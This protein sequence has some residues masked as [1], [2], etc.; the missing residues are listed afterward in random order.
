MCGYVPKSTT[1]LAEA[2]NHQPLFGWESKEKL[3]PQK[4]STSTKAKVLGDTKLKQ[5]VV[6]FVQRFDAKDSKLGETF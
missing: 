2:L 4:T 5:D 6:R 1:T 3:L